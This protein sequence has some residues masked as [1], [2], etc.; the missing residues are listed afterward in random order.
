MATASLKKSSSS[1]VINYKEPDG[2]EV[3]RMANLLPDQLKAIEESS[4]LLIKKEK[5]W[6]LKGS[7]W[8]D[9]DEAF[10]NRMSA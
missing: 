10:L 5:K 8:T 2:T 9:D 7:P 3:N 1:E 4:A 6:K